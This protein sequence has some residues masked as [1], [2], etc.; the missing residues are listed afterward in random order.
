MN[1]LL[2][3]Q[4][5]FRAL[6][7]HLPTRNT[8][9]FRNAETHSIKDDYPMHTNQ[10]K[11][12]STT[13]IAF[14]KINTNAEPPK[15]KLQQKLEVLKKQ[16]IEMKAENTTTF[17]ADLK[18]I[19]EQAKTEEDMLT[20]IEGKQAKFHDFIFFEKS[21]SFFFQKKSTSVFGCLPI[22][23]SKESCCCTRDLPNSFE[24]GSTIE[25]FESSNHVRLSKCS[26]SIKK[27]RWSD[28]DFKG[29]TA[30]STIFLFFTHFCSWSS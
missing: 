13:S 11:N 12:I 6:S 25:H 8:L 16:M 10:F 20:Y 23:I 22:T 28:F 1:R 19:I 3:F 5:R 2:L 21:Q 26:K 9:S 14:N 7:T 17:E 15:S 24:V 30:T 18:Q 29:K 4:K 27:I